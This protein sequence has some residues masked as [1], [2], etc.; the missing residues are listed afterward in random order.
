MKSLVHVNTKKSD[1]YILSFIFYDKKI[2]EYVLKQL[3]KN[4]QLNFVEV[5][6]EE[7]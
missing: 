5:N 3:R 4:K 7:K 2:K 1:K 6:N